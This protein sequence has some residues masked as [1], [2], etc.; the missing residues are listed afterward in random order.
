MS[1]F[2]AFRTLS[3]STRDYSELLSDTW[4]GGGGGRK[5]LGN[6]PLLQV[7]GMEKDTGVGLM[8]F[9]LVRF[10]GLDVV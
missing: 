2:V 1:L 3:K 8:G 10:N 6:G 4:G 5:V 7:G 9:D